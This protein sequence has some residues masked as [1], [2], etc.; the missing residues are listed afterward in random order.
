MAN[1]HDAISAAHRETVRSA[2]EAAFGSARADRI[3]L[4]GGG[5]SGAFPFRVRIGD[6]DY[7][8][9]VEGRASPLRNLHQYES[10]RIA[11]DAGI[12]PKVHHI[13]ETA[14]V[15]VMDFVEEK[16]LST[17][18]G[19]PHALAHAVGSI[20]GR[21]KRT[22]PF[23]RFI[24]YPEVVGRLWRWVRQTGLFAPGV[25]DPCTEH[26]ARIR[27]AYVWDAAEAASGHND[28]VPRNILFDGR[29]LWLVDWESAYCNDPLVD[30]A[31]VLDSFAPSPELEQVLLQAWLGDDKPSASLDDRL[32]KAR[33]LTRLYYAGVFLSASAAASGPLGDRDLSAPTITA[34][35]RAVHDGQISPGSPEAKHILGKMYLASFM[36]G[37]IP[38]GLDAAV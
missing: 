11:S 35:R 27:E 22:P 9:R 15:V 21:V 18:P 28:P 19:G 1:P 6:R 29:R 38:P 3:A 24:E 23:P 16:P 10:M 14:R 26:L 31:I 12:A 4:I 13:D 25:L 33:A 34:F 7:L 36:T 5:A 37:D 17:Y 20:L 30:L 2:L 8:V 32:P